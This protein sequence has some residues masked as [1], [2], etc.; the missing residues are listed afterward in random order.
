M[1]MLMFFL[2]F[3]LNPVFQEECVKVHGKRG[4]GFMGSCT[5]RTKGAVPGASYV[6]PFH[7][8]LQGLQ[9]GK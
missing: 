9:Q 3:F 5:S 2:G 7:T 4:G 8:R 1:I 6:S